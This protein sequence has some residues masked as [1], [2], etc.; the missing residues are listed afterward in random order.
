VENPE[1]ALIVYVYN[2]GEGSL[3]AIPI[4]HDILEWYFQRKADI[5]SQFV[6]PAES[7]APS[8]SGQ[9]MP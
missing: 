3:T 5:A 8:D 2:G 4:A 6:T 7:P 1:I 9:S